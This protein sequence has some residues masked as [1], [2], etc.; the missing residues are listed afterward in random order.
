[1]K[2]GDNIIIIAGVG[3][4]GLAAIEIAKKVFKASVIAIC[5]S[6]N[7]K[8]LLRDDCAEKA[9]SAK[10]GLTKVYKFLDG[11]NTK[12]KA[13]YDTVNCGLLYVTADL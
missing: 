6:D 4:N 3:G 1:M 12:I 8:A 2:E 11:S 10:V 5:D 13:V 7:T 9:I